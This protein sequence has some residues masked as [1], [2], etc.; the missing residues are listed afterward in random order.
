MDKDDN[1]DRKLFTLT[2]DT[3]CDLPKTRL[4]E[5]KIPYIPLTFTINGTVFHD[6]FSSSQDYLNFY[7]TLSSGANVT[8]SQINPATHAEFFSSLAAKGNNT[9]VHLSLSGGLSATYSSAVLGA[10][11][12]MEA[13]TDCKIFVVDTLSATVAHSYILKKAYEMQIAG[14][15]GQETA[16]NL[17]ELKYNVHAWILADDLFHLS[18]GGR[19]N[20][21]AAAIGTVL[22]IKPILVINSEG[23]LG[24]VA[25]M[26]GIKKGLNYF[27]SQLKKNCENY[28]NAEIFI[29]SADC[30]DKVEMLQELLRESGCKG[31]IDVGWIG[32]VIGAH[33]GRGT[34]GLVFEGKKRVL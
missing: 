34:L 9:I 18:R 27:V 19:I 23:S 17:N 28:Q 24:V 15:S 8:T 22:K 16:E 14:K 26:Q 30:P 1:S 13:H 32:P 3:S 7:S 2:T 5:L 33:T 20:A 29:A 10:K 21:A 31:N 6:E 11:I 4:S 12:A 25:K